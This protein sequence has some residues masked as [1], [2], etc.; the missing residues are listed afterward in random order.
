MV[1]SRKMAQSMGISMDVTYIETAP[2]RTLPRPCRDPKRPGKL[3][4]QALKIAPAL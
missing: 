1:L 2:W 4:Y 3:P